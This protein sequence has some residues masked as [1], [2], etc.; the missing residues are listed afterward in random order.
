MSFES[1]S[2]IVDNIPVSAD[3]TPPVAKC[4]FQDISYGH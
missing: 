2:G 4:L 3:L 1:L